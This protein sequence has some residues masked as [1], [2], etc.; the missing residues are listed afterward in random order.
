MQN[1]TDYQACQVVYLFGS[2]VWTTD[3]MLFILSNT[4]TK[5]YSNVN[6]SDNTSMKDPVHIYYTILQTY[7]RYNITERIYNITD[8]VF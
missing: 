1:F 8:T 5:I 3:T 7:S 2:Y 6:V 4:N